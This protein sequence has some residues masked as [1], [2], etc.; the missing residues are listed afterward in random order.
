MRVNR[1]G[2]TRKGRLLPARAIWFCWV[3]LLIVVV[4]AARTGHGAGQ[5]ET[6]WTPQA[7][8]T[9]TSSLPGVV[10]APSATSTQAQQTNPQAANTIANPKNKEIVDDTANLLKLAN[11]LKAEVD[12]TSADTLSVTVIRKAG[13]IEQLAHKMR[14][15]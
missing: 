2:A 3:V 7:E 13:E 1:I 12:K 14:A 15:Q 6:P 11:T 10:V 5:T 4:L 8:G 9:P